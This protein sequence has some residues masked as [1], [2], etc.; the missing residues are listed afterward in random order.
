MKKKKLENLILASEVQ[1]FVPFTFRGVKYIYIADFLRT[2]FLKKINCAQKNSL[3]GLFFPC[4][5]PSL[6]FPFLL[7]GCLT[8]KS[9]SELGCFDM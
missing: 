1:P 6:V 2:I 9:L 4:S 7:V 5:V 3:L 8:S